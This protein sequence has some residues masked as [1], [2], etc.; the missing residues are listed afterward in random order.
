M[1]EASRTILVVEDDEDV[2]QV[3]VDTLEVGGFSAVGVEDG[4]AALAWLGSNPRP[5]FIL[6]D[7]MMPRMDG[8]T[9]RRE[10]LQDPSLADIPVVFVSASEDPTRKEPL[11][12]SAAHLRKPISS[13]DLLRVA[14]RFARGAP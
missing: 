2:R 13:A 10:Q 14:S 11:L 7:I 6:L 4:L 5:S 8:V 3:V 12:S 1:A 9:F